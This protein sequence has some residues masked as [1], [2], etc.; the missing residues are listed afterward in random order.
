MAYSIMPV[1][2]QLI[3][4]ATVQNV[5][6][7]DMPDPYIAVQINVFDQELMECLNDTNFIISYFN[8]FI[9]KDEGGNMPQWDT[10]Y[11]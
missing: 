3:A 11:P 1:S 9:I 8:V 6:C 10:W 2:S 4:E 5:T 7:N